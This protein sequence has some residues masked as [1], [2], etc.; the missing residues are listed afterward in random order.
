MTFLK[1]LNS[2]FNFSTFTLLPFP[3]LPVSPIS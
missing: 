2:D 1:D 3:L